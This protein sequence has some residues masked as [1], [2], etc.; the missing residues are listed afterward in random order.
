MGN[1][2]DLVIS[3]ISIF[4]SRHFQRCVFIFDLRY[5]LLVVAVKG[6]GPMNEQIRDMFYF[7][8]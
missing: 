4:W 6:H 7:E 1:A 3:S 2:Q 5:S 8:H